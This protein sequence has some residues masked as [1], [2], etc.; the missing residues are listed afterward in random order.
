MSNQ[1]YYQKYIKYKQKYMSAKMIQ[2]GGGNTFK[3]KILIIII[4]I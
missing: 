2:T 1:D 3:L 4:V